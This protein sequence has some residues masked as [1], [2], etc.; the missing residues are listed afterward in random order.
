MLCRDV[1]CCE[2][3]DPCLER[4]G[5][6]AFLPTLA[7]ALQVV[8]I[9][10]WDENWQHC[11]RGDSMEAHQGS[12]KP[13]V[14]EQ[15]HS[16]ILHVGALEDAVCVTAVK[17]EDVA[18]GR[19][20]QDTRCGC[21]GHSTAFF[22][23]VQLINDHGGCCIPTGWSAGCCGHCLLLR[24]RLSSYGSTFGCGFLRFT[25]V[26]GGAELE[27]LG[28]PCRCLSLSPVK[29]TTDEYCGC[30][31][32]P[33]ASNAFSSLSKW[34]ASPLPYSYFCTPTPVRPGAWAMAAKW[35][36][37]AV[38]CHLDFSPV[39]RTP[40]PQSLKKPSSLLCCC[41]CGRLKSR[42]PSSSYAR[43][44]PSE[45]TN[46]HTQRNIAPRTRSANTLQRLET[47]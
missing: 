9:R 11:P 41:K 47:V 4:C 33:S 43:S 34:K 27:R 40:H 16:D 21:F 15:S 24:A 31:I 17:H 20:A 6:D 26:A 25:A 44:S 29:Y 37:V 8:R 5:R 39:P 38:Y 28:P 32:V 18:L 1:L 2:G 13:P 36:R 19:P 7:T 14:H 45:S 30:F 46:S 3:K 22:S 23:V 42:L 12:L 35:A 10:V